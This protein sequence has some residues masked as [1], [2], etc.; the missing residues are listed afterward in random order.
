VA[1]TLDG[2]VPL[3]INNELVK[4]KATE[5]LDVI[6]P[7][8]QEKIAKVPI[9]TADEMQAATDAAQAAF[10]A[11]R[12]TPAPQRARVLF[13]WQ[14]LLREHTP[15][16][17][18]AITEEQ[19][20]TTADAHGDV[21]RGLE[22][23]EHASG[24]G[25]LQMG[26]HVSGVSANMDSYE[27][28][29]PLGVCGGIVPFNFPVMCPMWMVPVAV[30]TGNTFVLKPSEK[31]PG[32]MTMVTQLAI[33]AGLPPGVLN[34]IQ[35][36]VDCVNHICDAPEIK[37][38]SFVGSNPAGEYIYKRANSN[39]KRVQCNMGA[40]NHTSIMPDA[41]RNHAVN[42]VVGAA[43][44]AAGQ[45][46]MALSVAVMVGESKE[47]VDDIVASAKNLKVG[48]GFD[49]DVDVGP[50][51]TP[52]AKEKAERL[53][54]SAIDQGAKVLLDG[55]GIKPDGFENGNFVGPT[56]VAGVTPDMDIY[57]EEVFGPVIC[58]MEADTLEDS[59]E[60]INANEWG[61]GASIF[62][63]NG[64]NARKF[65]HNVDAGQLGINVAIPVALPMFSFSGAKKS[66]WG[67][68]HMY[69]KMGVQFYTRA[70]TVTAAW[71]ETDV[72]STAKFTVMP[73]FGQKKD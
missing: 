52:A 45:R 70:Q 56:V 3:I 47:W 9:S 54:Q 2:T 57:K 11:W 26:G 46:C 73:T 71:P 10:P 8:T 38:V 64:S 37:A 43:F 35:G 72:S 60:I 33:E 66:F 30:A 22:V 24:M 65:Q 18:K 58:L 12:N 29:Q 41:N 15:E 42:S 67:D 63:T 32:A 48:S 40:K 31:D 36:S 21:F 23:V 34:L 44:G 51:I 59:I 49:P 50:L 53:I 20:K 69:G 7:A 5:F 55:R 27:I 4:S 6:N 16:L 17:V 39:G 68:L 19:G 28:R 62:T 13:K 25:S 14:Q 1:P 61:N